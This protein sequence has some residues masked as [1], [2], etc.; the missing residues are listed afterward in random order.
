M[1]A[2]LGLVERIAR[3]VQNAGTYGAVIEGQYPYSEA[4]RL[5]EQ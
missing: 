2:C 1:R 5:F 3:E 4:N